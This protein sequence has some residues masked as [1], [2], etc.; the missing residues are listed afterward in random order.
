[1][2]AFKV[3][4]KD[5]CDKCSGTGATDPTKKQKCN[6]CRGAGQVTVQ[7][8]MGPGMIMQQTVICPG[9]QGRKESI[10]SE[11]IC[12]GCNGSCKVNNSV[13]IEYFVKKGTGY[14]DF[15]IEGKGD[16]VRIDGNNEIRGHIILQV[17]PVEGDKSRFGHL[18][19]IRNDLI[20]EHTLTL[21]EAL[22]GFDLH[23][24]HMDSEENPFVLKCRDRVVQPESIVE[25]PG[26][27]MPVVDERGIVDGQFGKLII[28]FHIKFPET[29]SS[30]IKHNLKTVLPSMPPSSQLVNDHELEVIELDN[31][32]FTDLKS[33]YNGSGD[34]TMDDKNPHL[35][36]V[37]D[38]EDPG[39]HMGGG[40]PP[41]CA[42]Q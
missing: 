16:F 23:I 30:I 17:R 12:G 18:K 13:R 42:Q 5:R 2:I 20:Y 4:V 38:D 14:G 28:I 10:P 33:K 11:F 1:M 40:G 36:S 27:G 29:L 39:I 22:T 25:V 7:R 26:K 24:L 21:E 32:A 41:Q 34:N 31:M 9:C 35:F 37:D 6:S 19:R 15:P 8:M 3:D